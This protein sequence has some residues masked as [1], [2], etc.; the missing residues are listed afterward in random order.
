MT[1]NTLLAGAVFLLRRLVPVSF[2]FSDKFFRH[3]AWILKKCLPSFS[4]TSG[5]PRMHWGFAILGQLC[6]QTQCPF[7]YVD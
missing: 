4:N 5:F 3:V 7:Q 1:R 6:S 2:P